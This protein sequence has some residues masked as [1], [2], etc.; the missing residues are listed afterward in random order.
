MW[1]LSLDS[2]ELA[3]FRQ[4]I[5]EWTLFE[6]LKA[7]GF[8]TLGSVACLSRSELRD[9]PNIGE[10][11][12]EE[13]TDLLERIR[14]ALS[15][16][17]PA[18]GSDIPV[19]DF[20]WEPQP[21]PTQARYGAEQH[22]MPEWRDP[23]ATA[24]L[25]GSADLVDVT[26]RH[27][28]L[29]SEFPGLTLLAERSL[30]DPVLRAAWVEPG[31]HLAHNWLARTG[32]ARVGDLLSFTAQD[33]LEL[34]GLGPTKVRR[35]YDYLGR[36]AGVAP[37]V[38]AFDDIAAAPTPGTPPVDPKR[39]DM[40]DVVVLW[41]SSVA[42]A[43][44]WG[45]ALEVS[46]EAM[47]T[48]VASA[49][50]E[51]LAME[52]PALVETSPMA[53]FL[54]EDPRRCRVLLDRVASS[55]PR[56]LQEIAAEFGVTRERVRQIESKGLASLRSEFDSSPA[57]RVVRWAA[58]R[59][60]AHAGAYAPGDALAHALPKWSPAERHLVARLAG[61]EGF[62]PVL[63]REG[64]KLP[65]LAE[66]PTVAD[67]DFVVDEYELVERL[68]ALGVLEQHI[69]FALSS[70]TGVSR[71]DGQLVRW[72]GSIVD[73][74]VAVLEV[75]DEPQHI[76]QL[77]SAAYG[78][79]GSRS[80]RN[81][82]FEDP[83]FMRVTKNKVGL[84]R[85]GG[86]RYS[87]VA[88]LMLERLASGPMDLDELADELAKRY[89]IAPASVRMYAG[90]PAFKSTGDV[91]ALRS[92]R[93]PYVPR[94]KPWKVRGLYRHSAAGVTVW[95]TAVDD[96]MLRGS[97]RSIPQEIA[98]DLGLRPGDRT[99]LATATGPIPVAWSETTHSGPHIGSIRAILEVLEASVGDQLALRFDLTGGGLEV[100]LVP[101]ATQN[102]VGEDLG[103]LT[104]LPKSVA[105]HPTRLAA[106]LG[107]APADLVPAL[108]ARGD[109]EVASLVTRL[110]LDA[111][112]VDDDDTDRTSNL[113]ARERDATP[114]D[115]HPSPE[116]TPSIRSVGPDRAGEE[117]IDPMHDADSRP[118][119]RRTDPDRATLERE[120]EA[121][122]ADAITQMRLIGH[123]PAAL[124]KL[125]ATVGACRAG[126][127][128]ADLAEPTA[129]FMALHALG[130]LDLS[131]E[132]QMS[133]RPYRVLFGSHHLSRI[134]SRLK[135]HGFEATL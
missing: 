59:A 120:F 28:T 73:K 17:D 61:Y 25:A 118:T 82:I 80:A 113:T 40:L 135:E 94:H 10:Q 102:D 91:V 119:D 92:P 13:V 75:R 69:E 20:D 124:R 37:A 16:E 77:I 130:R 27:A 64:M 42:G 85:W 19:A 8:T 29:G 68:H 54:D 87:G 33:M 5:R 58:A 52:L 121:A 51:L 9:V 47:P 133:S 67:T 126:E 1:E 114:A 41:A 112:G 11:S 107:V 63:I 123:D 122:V 48:D 44:T 109:S 90:A 110:P 26:V 18:Q 125:V 117:V 12:V 93:D 35:L 31:D 36:L 62:D 104:T 15:W 49:W 70:I 45:E 46:A 100:Q 71:V 128:I 2:Q 39:S 14:T 57:W 83:R 60:E 78:E 56:T 115:E 108:Q 99:E 86:S 89:E 74:A 106:A 3:P 97:G 21:L 72:S 38:T 55:E 6:L 101:P 111:S 76:D 116:G 103:R 30:S 65:D 79:G 53:A 134:I 127:L 22:P 66:L 132:V 81:R 131:L 98:S 96:D 24:E 50:Q 7:D 23:S 88:E 4:S 84:Q 43:T 105:A 129:A 32:A 34:R 95:C